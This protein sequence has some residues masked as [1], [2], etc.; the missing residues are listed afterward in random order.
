MTTTAAIDSFHHTRRFGLELEFFNISQG[1]VKT[2]LEGAGIMSY[3]AQVYRA[4][5]NNNN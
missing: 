1:R 2:L 3:S 5:N 4:T